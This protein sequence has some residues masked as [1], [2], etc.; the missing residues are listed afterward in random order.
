M[1]GNDTYILQQNLLSK[2]SGGDNRIY[3][4]LM[5]CVWNQSEQPIVNNVMTRIRVVFSVC[6]VHEITGFISVARSS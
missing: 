4:K 1:Y 3:N 5:Q 6:M 2:N